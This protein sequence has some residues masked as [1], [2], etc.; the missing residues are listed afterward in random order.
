MGPVTADLVIVSSYPVYTKVRQYLPADAKIVIVNNTITDEQYR[1]VAELPPGLTVL[2]VNYSLEMTMDT[3]SMFHQLGLNHLVYVPC[4]PG[5]TQVPHLEV[6]VTPG[7]SHHVPLCVKR[8]VDIGDRVMD[9]KTVIT[10]AT[11]LGMDHL[12]KEDRFVQY[13][14][15]IRMSPGSVTMLFDRTNLLEGQLSSLLDVMDDGIV[16]VGEDGRVFA[17]NRKA[18][19]VMGVQDKLVGQPVKDLIPGIP[20]DD[21]LERSHEI[22]YTLVKIQ[23]RDIS[24]KVVPVLAGGALAIINR[25]EEKERNQHR[26]RAQMLGK[27]HRARYTFDQIHSRN[28]AFM[29]EKLLAQRKARSEASILI[30]GETGTGKELFAQ[31]I[32]Q[33]SP[34]REWPFVAVN[35]AA[36]PESLLES[37]LFGYEEGAFTGAR[38]GG[39]PGLFELAHKGTLFLDE[40][41]EM[42]LGLQARLLRVLENREVMRI[43]GDRMINVDIRIIAATNKQLWE[44]VERGGFRKDLYFR[45]NVLSI[46]IPPLRERTDDIGFLLERMFHARNAHL[47]LTPEASSLLQSYPWPGNVRELK[48]LAEYLI[49]LRKNPVEARDIAPMLSWPSTGPDPGDPGQRAFL[50][51]IGPDRDHCRFLLERLH[52][53]YQNQRRSGRRGLWQEARRQGRNLSEDQVRRLLARLE[54]L[55]KV[56]MGSGRSGTVITQAGIETLRQMG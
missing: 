9:A 46:K 52:A 37:E 27:G 10:I 32:H 49:Y 4:Y 5:A 38:R 25:F 44:C 29:E 51:A 26:L 17:N 36:L 6:A 56:R 20:F 1:Q 41:G 19:E 23:S 48:N 55:G 2:L 13:F 15:G 35:C 47:D 24:V 40:I 31:A 34:R 22:D 43:G 3:I 18:G 16:I 12:L 33:A 45:L 8:I 50:D 7:E 30:M 11:A 54:E 53:D 39:K 14:R 42:D 21:V 28:A